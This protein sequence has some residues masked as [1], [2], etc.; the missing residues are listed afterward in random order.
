MNIDTICK[1]GKSK[2]IINQ[3][4]L[5]HDGPVNEDDAVDKLT[6]FVAKN[7]AAIKKF[8]M[9]RK[10]LDSQ[11][12]LVNN[13]QLVCEE[14]AN[15]LVLWCLDL[16]MEEKFE[17]LNHVSHQCIVMQF[18]LEL[19]K[20]LK[21]DPRSCVRPFFSKF[22]NPEPEYDKMFNEELSAFKQRIR[23]RAKVK[24]KEALERYEMDERQKRLGPGGLDPVEV[25]ESLPEE[26]QKCF[27]SK[28]VDLLKTTLQK[29]EPREAEATLK[30]CIDSGLWLENAAG[31]D[32]DDIAQPDEA[33]EETFE[34]AIEQQPTI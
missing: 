20:S 12:F 23:D 1:E 16:A 33:A 30:L 11:N 5:E 29:M 7:D 13:S 2:T 27:E 22:I 28:N 10:P 25:F 19:A 31:D 3:A 32:T 26:L 6:A 21:C 17:L 18:L 34:D 8:G 24:V 15:Q 9:F 14:T 4:A